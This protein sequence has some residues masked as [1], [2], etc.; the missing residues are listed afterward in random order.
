MRSKSDPR[1]RREA[2]ISAA[3]QLFA[4]RGYE[5]VSIRDVLDAVGD[6]SSSPSVFYYY[7]KSKDELYRCAAESIALAYVTSF[8]ESFAEGPATLSERLTS[9]LASIQTGLLQTGAFI[10]ES[11]NMQNRMFMLDMREQVTE[12]IA[13]KWAPLLVREGIATP[14]AA[15]P[16]AL[17]VSG[18]I[19]QLLFALLA[20][21]TPP[22]EAARVAMRNIV[23][24][25][26]ATLGVSLDL[27]SIPIT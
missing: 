4:E 6:R 7:F 9:A 10:S 27:P 11:G 3:A 5:H 13:A 15:A 18:G 20:N 21:G 16:L 1:I 8:D 12:A 22:D 25:T 17:Y 19:G 23:L 26:T 2:F 24:F 14:E